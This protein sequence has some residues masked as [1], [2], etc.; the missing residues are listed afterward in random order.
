MR[1]H[2]RAPPRG[3]LATRRG[4]HAVG[5]QQRQPPRGAIEQRRLQAVASAGFAHP[6]A[7]RLQGT[8]GP[9]GPRLQRGACPHSPR[10]SARVGRARAAALRA[11]GR[12]CSATRAGRGG[13]PACLRPHQYSAPASAPSCRLGCSAP[14][15]PHSR[16]R[17]AWPP[18]APFCSRPPG[19]EQAQ[20]PASLPGAAARMAD[21]SHE[22]VIH[23]A[24]AAL[25]E[26]TEA[27]REKRLDDAESILFV[28]LAN[29]DKAAVA[30]EGGED[31]A[32]VEIKLL[33]ARVVSLPASAARR[34]G[35]RMGATGFAPM[36]RRQGSWRPPSSWSGRLLPRIGGC[37]CSWP[38]HGRGCPHGCSRG[39]CLGTGARACVAGSR[40]AAPR[41]QRLAR[42]PGERKAAPRP[43]HCA[44]GCS[45][46]L[47]AR[48]SATWATCCTARGAII[49]SR[50][51]STFATRDACFTS[52]ATA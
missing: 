28:V 34:G 16:G 47:A 38:A 48:R 19:L 2:A 20:R 4:S 45:G 22:T 9:R 21:A 6:R 32:P 23:A 1:R 24:V 37:R 17:L 12:R 49:W 40:C 8:R 33:K 50:R 35:S 36:H 51:W 41:G 3:G 13:T 46:G 30:C 42:G 10:A 29:V 5:A 15:P 39:L 25:E 52:S 43:P 11:A 44:P 31:E 26:A 7:R 27:M 18:P 14:G